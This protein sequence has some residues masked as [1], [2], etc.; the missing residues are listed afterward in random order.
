M[1]ILFYTLQSSLYS[2]DALGV[3]QI[4]PKNQ[5]YIYV[6]EH[7]IHMSENETKKKWVKDPPKKVLFGL[8]LILAICIYLF[9]DNLPHGIELWWAWI[10]M[11]IGF[12]LIIDAIIRDLNIRDRWSTYKRFILAVALIEGSAGVIYGF[13]RLT[14]IYMTTLIFVILYTFLRGHELVKA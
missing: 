5:K 11:G 12:L 10:I 1:I 8:F 2:Y 3:A 7:K 14:G 6:D 13:G 9:R 4:Y